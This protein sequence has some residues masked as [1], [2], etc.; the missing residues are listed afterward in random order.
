MHLINRQKAKSPYL[1][2]KALTVSSIALFSF[3]HATG[4]GSYL[5]FHRINFKPILH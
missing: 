3:R 5:N 4:F 2:P 1:I